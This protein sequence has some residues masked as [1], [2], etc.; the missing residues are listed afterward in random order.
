MGFLVSSRLYLQG[1]GGLRTSEWPTVATDHGA[2]RS[3]FARGDLPPCAPS[4]HQTPL[5]VAGC[6]RPSPRRLSGWL[7]LHL[8]RAAH[9]QARTQIKQAHIELA[10]PPTPRPARQSFTD[11]LTRCLSGLVG[12]TILLDNY[13]APPSNLLSSAPCCQ[14]DPSP[15]DLQNVTAAEPAHKP[16]RRRRRTKQRPMG[17]DTIDRSNMSAP[18]IAE[19]GAASPSPPPCVHSTSKTIEISGGLLCENS[20]RDPKD[21]PGEAVVR[22]S[23]AEYVG[24]YAVGGNRRIRR[25]DLVYPW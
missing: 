14:A 9:A 11:N 3:H 12:P 2:G 15:S 13:P 4:V 19:L 5:L 17:R 18:S 23:K 8:A 1:G 24:T 20:Q 10:R 7:C 6:G 25:E 22:S 21:P 16:D